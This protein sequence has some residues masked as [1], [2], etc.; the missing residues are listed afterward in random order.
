MQLQLT[1]IG[2]H[3][4]IIIIVAYIHTIHTHGIRHAFT[5]KKWASPPTDGRKAVR[6]TIACLYVR[7]KLLRCLGTYNMKIESV[8][9]ASLLTIKILLCMRLIML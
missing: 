5:K 8:S 3:M 7:Y 4:I 9:R 6:I 1:Y 2:M